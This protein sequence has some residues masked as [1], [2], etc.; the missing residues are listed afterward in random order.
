[1]D[2]CLLDLSRHF[3]PA[4]LGTI[5]CLFF[6]WF[7]SSLYLHSDRAEERCVPKQT[8]R[9]LFNWNLSVITVFPPQ[10][11]VKLLEGF[12]S[13][14]PVLRLFFI[15]HGPCAKALKQFYSWQRVI[16]LYWTTRLEA[17]RSISGYFELKLNLFTS[18]NMDFEDRVARDS[19]R[20]VTRTKRHE[21]KIKLF[22]FLSPSS[23]WMFALNVGLNLS[24]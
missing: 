13:P 23:L 8:P 3:C 9:T 19:L 7:M 17:I 15:P 11:V 22:F 5:C 20:K 16:L 14:V 1:M 4:G 24:R 10:P 18:S 12:F 2:D 6:H 21:D